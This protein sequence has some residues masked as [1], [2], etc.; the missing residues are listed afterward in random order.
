MIKDSDRQ[1]AWFTHAVIVTDDIVTISSVMVT[2][3]SHAIN[4]GGFHK[5][6]KTWTS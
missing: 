5:K 3:D 4:H 2:V 6:Q 1:E